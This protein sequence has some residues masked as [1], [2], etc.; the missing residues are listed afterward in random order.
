MLAASISFIA[1]FEPASI[2]VYGPGKYRFIDFIKTGI[3]LTIVLI[4]LVL[5]V[6]PV[7]WPLYAAP[8]R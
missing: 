7:F 5:V 6:L 2:L 1:P 3:L 4:F 8:E